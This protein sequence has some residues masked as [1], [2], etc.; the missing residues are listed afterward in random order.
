MRLKGK[1]RV[2]R[3]KWKEGATFK[4]SARKCYTSWMH[5]THN[6][7][8]I[9]NNDIKWVGKAARGKGNVSSFNA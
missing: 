8:E 7:K 2:R 4:I 3:G 9:D 5:F 1:E 6:C